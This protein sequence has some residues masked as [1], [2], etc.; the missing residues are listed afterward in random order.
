MDK[1]QLLTYLGGCF[2]LPSA[3]LGNEIT[4]ESIDA[5]HVKASISYMGV[6]GSVD[7]PKWSLVYDDFRE[8]D[9]TFYLTRLK[10][11]WHD[12][13]GDLVYFDARDIEFENVRPSVEHLIAEADRIA[14]QGEPIPMENLFS[15]EDE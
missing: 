12:S 7:Y 3:V 10:T 9:G 14:E 5:T 2:L 11:I 15:A 4:W 13:K 8:K 6:N 1:A